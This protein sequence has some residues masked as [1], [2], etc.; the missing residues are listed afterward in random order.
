M[1]LPKDVV[2]DYPMARA[3]HTFDPPV[4]FSVRREQDP[5]GKVKLWDGTEPWLITRYADAQ[6]V[7]TDERFSAD[8]HTPGFPF[9]TPAV[10]ANLRF[11]QLMI[12]DD[13]PQHGRLR[14]MLN[15]DFM[16]RRMELL[17]PSVQ[18]LVDGLVD[19]LIAGGEPGD[20]VKT[21]AIPLPSM[22]ICLL[23][24]VPYEDHG[25]FQQRT[26]RVA[27]RRTSE[28]GV[29]AANQELSE[30]MMRLVAAKDAEPGDDLVSRLVVEQY[31]N[32][33]ITQQ[34]IADLARMILVAGHESTAHMTALSVLALLRHPDQLAELT[35]HPA[36]IPNAV[37]ELLRY[38]TVVHNGLPR[39][40]KED[41]EIGGQL[42]KAGE[43]LLVALPSANRDDAAFPDADRLDVDRPSPR[44][45]TFG[46]GI[47]HCL[48]HYLARVEVQVAIETLFRRLPGLR[49]AIPFEQLEFRHQMAVYGVFELPV[50]WS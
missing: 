10:K 6:A 12:R 47:H 7:L 16:A 24:G 2:A 34:E 23:L 4:T 5:V 44:H 32:G 26:L 13:D 31:R 50:R 15:K 45:L 48:G 43:G 20:L 14:R 1:S 46:F 39:A 33:A 38:L 25:F 17:R 40:A 11:R 21:F 49:L 27:D 36:K 8:P 9:I 18:R 28:E 37:E 42:I 41:V 3:S 19:D 30:Y 29:K 22:V 35:A